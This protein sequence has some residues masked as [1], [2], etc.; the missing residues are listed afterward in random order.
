MTMDTLETTLSVNANAAETSVVPPLGAAFPAS[1]IVGGGGGGVIRPADASSDDD[2]VD[3]DD[4]VV[5]VVVVGYPSVRPVRPVRRRRKVPS[6]RVKMDGWMCW[7]RRHA[8]RNFYGFWFRRCTVY[9]GF[10]Y[11]LID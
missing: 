2:I 5:V 11:R 9:Y 10:L 8:C 3:D 4:V 7:V 1:R 6:S